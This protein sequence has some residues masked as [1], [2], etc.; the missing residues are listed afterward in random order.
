MQKSSRSLSSKKNEK[1][2][3]KRNKSLQET[4][5]YGKF[6]E[7]YNS[8][9]NQPF[10]QF[11]YMQE[12]FN[13]NLNSFPSDEE[14]QAIQQNLFSVYQVISN[15]KKNWTTDEKKVLIWVVGK[16]SQS[17]DLDIR[18]L[19]NSFWDDVSELICRRDPQSCKQKWLQ[20]KKTDLQQKPFTQQEDQLLLDL[21]HKYK[22]SEQGK[23]WC[24]ISEE[25]N[26]QILNYRT[27]KQCRERWLNHLNPKISK[28][29]WNDDE[30]I[31]LL[32][33]I[34]QQGRKWAEISKLFD[35]RRNENT[36]KNRFNSLIKREKDLIVDL[37][38]GQ[39]TNLDTI[40]GNP[41][42][43]T[44]NKQQIMAIEV[45][46]NKIQWRKGQI[47]S[48]EQ[49]NDF[50]RTSIH[51]TSD[52]QEEFQLKRSSVVKYQVGH[53][54]QDEIQNDELVPCL[55]N[56]EKN[57]IYFCSKEQ[58]LKLLDNQINQMNYNLELAKKDIKSFD[59]GLINFKTQLSIISE[60][61]DSKFS[62][63]LCGQ[64]NEDNFSQIS[65]VFQNNFIQK[66]MIDLEQ[67]FNLDPPQHQQINQLFNPIQQIHYKA[68]YQVRRAYKS[69]VLQQNVKIIDQKIPRS[70]PNV[71][72]I[73]S[74]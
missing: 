35:G 44:L 15:R 19:P 25:L 17:Q 39:T 68:Y 22:D 69:E 50:R 40:F 54:G 63:F 11:L 37:Q 29:P 34:L 60:I 59:S 74:Q 16:L 47:K 24:Q 10:K 52:K 72:S 13:T 67:Y 71:I 6:L 64:N 12:F 41:T 70:L 9:Q 43:Q 55:V 28:D 33:L 20:L 14:I 21:I 56:L 1:L 57:I 36:V 31:F 53:L 5:S 51:Q 49:I 45:L 48:G 32:D 38:N 27:S 8:N 26:S 18:D 66:Q 58:I 4:E 2:I 23:K 46:K 7:F 30:D 62:S 65:R 3:S 73:I 61:N 42:G